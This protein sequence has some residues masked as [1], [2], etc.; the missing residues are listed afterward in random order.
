MM[1]FDIVDRAP[2]LKF[3]AVRENE[4]AKNFVRHHDQH[5]LLL[6]ENIIGINA[7]DH[8]LPHN[9]RTEIQQHLKIPLQSFPCSHQVCT[10]LSWRKIVRQ[11]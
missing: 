6:F 2:A 3:T 8:L 10:L 5:I 4:P 11:Q 7:N 1:M 9:M